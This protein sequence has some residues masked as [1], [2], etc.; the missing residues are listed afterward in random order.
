M[1]LCGL[2]SVEKEVDELL[3]ETRSLAQV[4]ALQ[5]DA[6]RLLT[7]S[8][9]VRLASCRMLWTSSLRLR[10]RQEMC[11]LYISVSSPVLDYLLFRPRTLRQ[12]LV[13]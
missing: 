4:R 2:C 1:L 12:R 9:Q 11:A 3:P 7:A 13:S 8:V 10:N 5:H 6:R